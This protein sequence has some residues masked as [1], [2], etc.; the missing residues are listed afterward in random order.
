MGNGALSTPEGYNTDDLGAYQLQLS[1]LLLSLYLPF[2]I[3][4]EGLENPLNMWSPLYYGVFNQVAP[5]NF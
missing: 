5:F 1:Q 3:I 4:S 2:P